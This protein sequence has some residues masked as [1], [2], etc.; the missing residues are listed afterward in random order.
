MAKDPAFLFY[1]NDFLT[2]VQDLT[3]EERGQY[4]TLLCLQH[5]K[6]HL[7]DKIIRLTCH[8]NA[9]ADV[10]AKFK[11][12]SDGLF[13]NSRLEIET[14]KR[15]VHSEKQSQRAKD[16]WDKRKSE[17]RG[18]AVA[19]AVAMPL[20]NENENEDVIDN[21][22][23]KNKGKPIK[24]FIPP[25]IEQVKEYFTENGYTETAAIK[26]FDYYTAGNWKDKNGTLVKN[27]KQKMIGVWFKDEYKESA[28]GKNGFE[29]LKGY[30][31]DL[32]GKP[33]FRHNIS[34]T[35]TAINYT[36]L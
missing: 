11:V 5:Q 36:R 19:Y 9:A 22:N 14:E 31:A 6:G 20:E 15:K 25:T 1:S 8:G 4:I 12:D 35:G 3:M 32:H 7:T 28:N 23:E 34:P 26:A 2:G 27:W 13:F 30:R 24:R 16:G 21:G 33:G 10:L 18:N 17:S 29:H